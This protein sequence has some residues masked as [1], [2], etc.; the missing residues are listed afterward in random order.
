MSENISIIVSDDGSHSLYRKDMDETYHS[1]RGAIAESR[2]VF[3]ESGLNY[4]LKENMQVLE[5]GF[6]TG[7]NALLSYIFSEEKN[8]VIHYHT[9]EPYPLPENI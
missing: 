3:I 1:R 4:L 5:V 7:L 8:A 9:L 6:G 2:Y